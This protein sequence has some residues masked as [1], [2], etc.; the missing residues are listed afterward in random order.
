MEKSDRGLLLLSA[1]V[2]HAQARLWIAALYLVVVSINLFMA[3]RN[4]R[5]GKDYSLQ[6][7]QA[8]LWTIVGF[9]FLQPKSVQFFEKGIRIPRNMDSRQSR[10]RFLPWNE[11]ERYY[12]DSDLLYLVTTQ[13]VL[14]SGG[15]SALGEP[16]AI[17]PR[18]RKKVD[19]ILGQYVPQPKPS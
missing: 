19:A 7:V 9:L 4:Y 8:V 12:W 16:W 5:S 10:S 1:P 17:Q 13:S 3:W 18:G 14:M 2:K 6:V 15:I 11:V